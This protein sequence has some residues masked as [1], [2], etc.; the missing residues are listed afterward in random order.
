MQ[1]SPQLKKVLMIFRKIAGRVYHIALH[2]LPATAR[3]ILAR[4]RQPTESGLLT[5]KGLHVELQDEIRVAAAK[6]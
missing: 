3:L 6:N 5:P 1:N 2:K 4:F